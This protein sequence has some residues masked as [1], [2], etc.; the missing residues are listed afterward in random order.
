[1]KEF[2]GI[3]YY[4]ESLNNFNKGECIIDLRSVKTL[5]EE[6]CYNGVNSIEEYIENLKKLS[7]DI[8]ELG[9]AI[10]KQDKLISFGYYCATTDIG[11]RDEPKT[12]GFGIYHRLYKNGNFSYFLNVSASE[13]NRNLKINSILGDEE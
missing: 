2:R 3:K 12:F 9:K 5:A 1:M 8:E 13:M 6:D 7:N 11:M 4:I 10:F